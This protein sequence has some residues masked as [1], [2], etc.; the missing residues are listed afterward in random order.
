M[1]FRGGGR[2]GG[3]SGGRG[4]AGGRRGG[5]RGLGPSGICR[6]IKRGREVPHRLGIPCNQT[7]GPECG[8]PMMRAAP[9]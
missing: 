2:F 7:M 4:R 1:S 8:I 5:G 6:C 9:N 3:G